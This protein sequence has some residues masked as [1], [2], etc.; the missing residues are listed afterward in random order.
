MLNLRVKMYVDGGKRYH[1]GNALFTPGGAPFDAVVVQDAV[2]DT[3]GSGALL[4]FIFPCV[5]AAWYA[6]EKAQVPVG[7]GVD[8][9]AVV[10]RR[11]GCTTFAG[12]QAL[13]DARAAPLDA[14]AVFSAETP[15][16]HFAPAMANGATVFVN[17]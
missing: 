13:D 4:H 7:L 1:E 11:T 16:N 8:Y 9:P 2:V 3:F 14:A 5:G 12:V 15:V 6:G 17:P 10:G